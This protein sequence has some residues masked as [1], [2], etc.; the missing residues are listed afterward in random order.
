MAAARASRLSLNRRQWLSA[1]AAVAVSGSTLLAQEPKAQQP[2]RPANLLEFAGGQAAGGGAVGAVGDCKDCGGLGFLPLKNRKPYF[3]VEGQP[4]PKAADAV[5]HRYCPTCQAGKDDKDLVAEQT[6]RFKTALD[7][8]QKWEKETGFNLLRV[9]TRH[10]EV[11]G[12]FPLPE[13]IKIG[14]AFE[15]LAAHLQSLTG[16]MELTQT[17]PESY[18]IVA[19]LEKP[20]MEH[21]RTVLEKIYTVEKLGEHWGLTKGV[22]A[23]DGFPLPFFYQTAADTKNRPY[24]HGICFLG[25]RK[26][27]RVATNER[28]PRWLQEGFAEYCEFAGM[29]A[30]LWRT[31]YNENPPPPLGSWAQQV[32]QLALAKQLRSWPEQMKREL[33]DYDARDYLQTFGMVAFLLQSDPQK[34]LALTRKLRTGLAE[35]KALEESYAMAIPALEAACVKWLAAGK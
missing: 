8:H 17:R 4:L 23:V 35:E 19:L 11:H 14:Q 33:R 3:H 22:P 28:A 6:E 32:R 15:S 2:K 20:A 16:T 26:Q 12:Q 24:A 30:N 9:E 29:K 7:G 25:G 13:A 18:E 10:V 5:P 21:F 27:V 34:F 1:S 31:V